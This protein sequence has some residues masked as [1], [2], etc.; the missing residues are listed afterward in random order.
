MRG[1][2]AD[3][4]AKAYTDEALRTA[5]DYDHQELFQ[6]SDSARAAG[7][8]AKRIEERSQAAPA[9]AAE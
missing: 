7:A 2:L 6:L 5:D 1:V 9:D 8:R 3:P 4:N